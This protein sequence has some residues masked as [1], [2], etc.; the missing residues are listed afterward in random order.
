M[1]VMDFTAKILQIAHLNWSS[2]HAN[3]ARVLTCNLVLRE[4]SL[5]SRK[6]SPE[7]T[8]TSAMQEQAEVPFKSWFS[9]R[10]DI[11]CEELCSW[12]RLKKTKAFQARRDICYN[13]FWSIPHLR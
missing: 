4:P 6:L 3:I 13:P 12:I 9:Y 7:A 10:D 11:I 8:L 1:G 2:A 5:L